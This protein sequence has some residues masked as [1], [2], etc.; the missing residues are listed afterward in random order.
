MGVMPL[1]GPHGLLKNFSVH[2]SGQKREV[3]EHKA[4]ARTSAPLSFLFWPTRA[5]SLGRIEAEGG[6]DAAIG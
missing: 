4:P 1:S 5:L 3:V 2:L 6:P